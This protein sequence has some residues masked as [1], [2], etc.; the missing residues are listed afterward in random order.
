MITTVGETVRVLTAFN[1]SHLH[2]RP[3]QMIWN[4]RT[5][6][7]GPVDFLHVTKKGTERIYHFSLCTEKGGMYI[8]LAFY[9]HSLTWV[10]EEIEDSPDQ[11]TL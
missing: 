5:H 1:S 7:L 8:R 4:D 3:V 6:R 2:A 9:T 11:G 10:L